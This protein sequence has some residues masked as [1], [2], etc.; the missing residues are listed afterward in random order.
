M[1]FPPQI[2]V[3]L[4]VRNPPLTNE[5]YWPAL[6]PRLTVF[7]ILNVPPCATV[8]EPPLKSPPPPQFKTALEATV[9]VPPIAPPAQLMTALEAT[10]NEPLLELPERLAA[11]CNVLL[12]VKF[13]ANRPL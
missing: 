11:P 7:E 9:I 13:S 2:T 6:Y 8:S 3:P 12:P 4:F 5:G 10:S 1:A